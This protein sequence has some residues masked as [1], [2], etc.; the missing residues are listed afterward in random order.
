MGMSA[1]LRAEVN[2]MIYTFILAVVIVGVAAGAFLHNK[3]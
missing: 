2:T 3:V 1:I